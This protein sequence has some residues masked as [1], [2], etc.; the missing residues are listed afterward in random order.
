MVIPFGIAN[1]NKYRDSLLL[2]LKYEE[3]ENQVKL[4]KDFS[5][6][7]Y[8][9][10][11]AKVLELT[12][13]LFASGI[14]MSL[15]SVYL[16]RLMSKAA[17]FKY[18]MNAYRQYNENANA[19]LLNYKG[20]KTADYYWLKSEEHTDV[21]RSLR[22]SGESKKALA[23]FFKA[24]DC[25]LKSDNN[26]RMIASYKD[27]GIYYNKIEAF[28]KGKNYFLKALNCLKDNESAEVDV[29]TMLHSHLGLSYVGVGKLDSAAYYLG[30]I[31]EKNYTI[32]VM[33]NMSDFYKK[34]KEFRKSNIYLDSIIIRVTAC[35]YANWLG[36][37]QMQ[38][39]DN[40]FELR[41]FEKAEAFWLESRM[42]ALEKNDRESIRE[43]ASRLY[44]YYKGRGNFEKALIFHEEF[45]SL[46]DSLLYSDHDVVIKG[47]EDS[48]LLIVKQQEN[49][50]LRKQ[51]ES[52]QQTIKTQRILGGVSFLALLLSGLVSLFY[53][54]SSKERKK[55]N[56]ELDV[57]NKKALQ[58]E[59]EEQAKELS[60]LT[61]NVPA[62]IAKLDEEFK[63]ENHNDAF[64]NWVIRSEENKITDAFE[65]M[66]FQEEDKLNFVKALEEAGKLSFAWFSKRNGLVYQVKLTPSSKDDSNSGYILLLEDITQ[67][68][69]SEQK[70]LDNAVANLDMI[71]A[72][73]KVQEKE[74]MKLNSELE[75]RNR[76]LASNM[77][78]LSKQTME[79][80][81]I[82]E[83]LRAL[84]T[85]S[86]ARTKQGLFKV[87][88]R[89]STALEVEDNWK[90]FYIYFEEVHPDFIKALRLYCEGLSNNEI[91]HCTFVKLGMTNKEV[92]ELLNLSSKTIE[93]AR[94]RI[95]KKLDLGRDES[96]HDF[97]QK[98][99]QR[100]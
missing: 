83:S 29:R 63:L 12:E 49:K 24:L 35:P 99:D 6:K 39:A 17:Y 89:L 51:K 82:L 67:L 13:E 3:G 98:I 2:E 94:Y 9:T 23:E 84:Y 18:D 27:L 42:N 91:R 96:L 79:L 7:F 90:S 57:L 22:L 43:V 44:D 58:K 41:Q 56:E 95:K 73:S 5:K 10:E 75:V 16:Y 50:S 64:F 77:I 85:K 38:K 54:R 15:D 37:A 59:L 20:K 53:Y 87:I 92:A 52:S 26:S 8:K 48:H 28:E 33:F 19:V 40:L 66:G 1:E 69:E 36:V 47:L 21:G 71:R 86:S 14:S 62:G 70:K 32:G 55:L 72:S 68:K 25:A 88:G 31:E 81:E 61:N 93:V 78:Q 45:K 97:I 34:R 65:L 11:S 100:R 80:Q 60:Y 4:V 30:K 76:K 74:N 46:S